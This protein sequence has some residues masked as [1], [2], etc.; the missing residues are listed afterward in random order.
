VDISEI[1]EELRKKREHLEGAILSLER[2]RPH[3]VPSVLYDPITKVSGRRFTSSCMSRSS[4]NIVGG[5]KTS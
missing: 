5:R 3:P 1:L 2:V 4:L